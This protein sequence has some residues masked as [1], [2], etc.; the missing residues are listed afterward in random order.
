MDY[1]LIHYRMSEWESRAY[2][3]LKSRLLA[4]GWPIEHLS[5]DSELVT[6]G[7][8]IDKQ[9]GNVVKANRFGYVKHAFHGSEPLGFDEKKATYRQTLVDLH[10]PRWVFMNTLFSISEAC[11]YMQLVDLLDQNE[12]PQ[13]RAYDDLYDKVRHSLDEAHIEGRLKAEI[14]ANPDRFVDLDANM[15]A[16]LL[17]QKYAGKKLLLITNSEW[18]FVAP[19]MSFVFDRYLPGD[20]TWS[21]LFDI[22]IVAARKPD[23]FSVRMPTFEVIDDKGLLNTHV[24]LL[25]PGGRYVGGNAGLVEE[26]LGLTGDQIMYVGD[27]I[28]ADVNV[29]KSI[30]RWRTALVIRELE[31]EIR[32]LEGFRSSETQLTEL[33]MEKERLEAKFSDARVRLQR[34]TNGYA[35]SDKEAADKLE[36]SMA[37]LRSR[38]LTLDEQIAPLAKA[39][40]RLLNERWGPL[41]RTGKD[42]SHLAR[43]IERY[44]DV[45]T[46]RVSNFLHQTPFVYLRAH[47]GSL[48]HD[49]PDEFGAYI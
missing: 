30:N 44:A 38:L 28:F 6:R 12:L 10:E 33:M 43:Q 16:A 24:G 47:R 17:D 49:K 37:K 3:Y 29:S 41:M 45:Y 31:D 32:A 40:T 19:M 39:S 1:T 11:M 15:P 48:P 14:I 22:S 13:V 8:I 5:F 42:K 4:A 35:G 36:A 2:Y 20:M 34:E 18:G 9:R 21:D 46:S 7:L 23:F 26:S 25:K 27:H